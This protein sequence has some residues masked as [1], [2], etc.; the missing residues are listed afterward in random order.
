MCY[1]EELSAVCLSTRA[2]GSECARVCMNMCTCDCHMP[3]CLKCA[4]YSACLGS[5]VRVFECWIV[6]QKA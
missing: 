6:L 2:C 5:R 1:I 4:R 3:V